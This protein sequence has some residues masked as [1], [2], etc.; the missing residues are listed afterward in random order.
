MRRDDVTL[1]LIEMRQ[2]SDGSRRLETQ[3]RLATRAARRERR[4][5]GPGTP[6]LPTVRPAAAGVRVWMRTSWHT[7]SGRRAGERAHR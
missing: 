7:L 6:R 3:A 5:A 1:A 2:V 4:K